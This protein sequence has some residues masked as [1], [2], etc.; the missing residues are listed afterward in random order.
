MAIFVW[1]EGLGYHLQFDMHT[2]AL[3]I[4]IYINIDSGDVFI[5]VDFGSNATILIT[6]YINKNNL[7]TI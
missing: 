3:Y 6:K 5:Y 2:Y 7:S 4:Y 1:I